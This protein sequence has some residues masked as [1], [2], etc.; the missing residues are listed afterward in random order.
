MTAWVCSF[1]G[2]THQRSIPALAIENFAFLYPP[3]PE[4]QCAIENE[5]HDHSPKGTLL[6][7]IP[8]ELVVRIESDGGNDHSGGAQCKSDIG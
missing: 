2:L 1:R 8:S 6:R 3:Y 4:S 5:V 7:R